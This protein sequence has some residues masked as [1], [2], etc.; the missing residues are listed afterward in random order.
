MSRAGAELPTEDDGSGPARNSALETVA[1]R[2]RM[3]TAA[4]ELATAGGYDAVQ[5]RDVAARAQVALGHPLPPL[6]VEGPAPARRARRAGRRAA[7]PA[8][9]A[10]ARRRGR[11]G[12][13]VADVLRRASARIDPRPEHHRRDGHRALRAR[14]R[15]R[16]TA[17]HEVFEILRTIISGAVD[18]ATVPDLDGIVRVLGYV[19]LATLTRGS[20]G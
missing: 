1:R 15:R 11:P 5:M 6:L 10:P 8:R 18:G 14:A 4:V 13:R 7:Q 9:A 20:A 16:P 3:V 12:D 19:W 2:E 17:K